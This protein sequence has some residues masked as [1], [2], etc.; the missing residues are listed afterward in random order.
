MKPYPNFQELE[1]LR[2]VTWQDLVELEPRLGKLLWRAR[3]AGA[4]CFCWADVDWV[5]PRIRDTIADLVGFAGDNHGH[6][7]LGSTGAYEVA[8]WK[9]YDAVAGWLRPPAGGAA[10]APDTQR[11]EPAG[12]TG[13]T[14][15]A[16]PATTGVA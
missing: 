13:P 3:L 12:E 7:V 11:G 8:Y 14:Q 1:R 2:G 16:A 6:P 5:F 9:L 4:C 10:E 15:T